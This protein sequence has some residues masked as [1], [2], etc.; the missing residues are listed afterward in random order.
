MATTDEN[1]FQPIVGNNNNT[2]DLISPPPAPNSGSILSTSLYGTVSPPS[3]ASSPSSNASP[4]NPSSGA[5]PQIVQ[6][7]QKLSQLNM[8]RTQQQQQMQQL[9]GAPLAQPSLGNQPLNQ[10][11][12]QTTLGQSLGQPQNQTITPTSILSPY[13]YQQSSSQS[14]TQPTLGQQQQQLQQFM[15]KMTENFERIHKYLS[16]VDQRIA[17]LE[18]CTR[19]IAVN[20]R[21]EKETLQQQYLQILQKIG[22]IRTTIPAPSQV[23]MSPFLSAPIAT[24]NPTSNFV[25][26][27]AAST[28]YKPSSKEQEDADAE[29]ARRLQAELNAEASK[30]AARVEPTEECPI[31]SEKVVKSKI[32]EHVNKHLDEDA[33]PPASS[34]GSESSIWGRL[35]GRGNAEAEKKKQEEEKK[36]QEESSRPSPAP[37]PAPVVSSAVP[38]QQ[39]YYLAPAGYALPPNQSQLQPVVYR[40]PQSDMYPAGQI[41]FQP[42]PQGTYPNLQ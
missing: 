26:A 1:P 21:T 14:V 31:C 24:P 10:S 19:E 7:Q 37:A 41:L 9:G 28:A 23:Q 30:P 38:F 18:K 6:N 42:A 40:P 2:N 11:F 27:P 17:A 39:P 36:K 33:K 16:D 35:F 32:E 4:L 3:S 25:A 20:Q 29:L 8:Y 15:A 5:P 22:E 13:P 34:A 12:T